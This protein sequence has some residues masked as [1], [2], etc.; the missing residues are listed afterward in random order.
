MIQVIMSG[1]L[2]RMGRAIAENVKLEENMRI[3]AGVDKAEGTADFPIYHD[4]RDVKEAADVIVDFSNPE[5]LQ[6]ICQYAE[7]HNIALVVGTTGIL[8]EDR[9]KLHAAAQKVPVI[10]SHNVHVGTYVFINLVKQA[11]KLLPDFDVEIVERHHNQKIDA[12]SGTALMIADAIR[13]V[14]NDAEYV[15]QRADKIQKRAKNE[16]GIYS[17]R[18]GNIIGQHTVIFAGDDEVIELNSNITSRKV[19][20]AGAVQCAKFIVEKAPG[21]YTL[22]DVVNYLENK[23]G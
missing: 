13:E 19:L 10:A 1:A 20:S 4:I 3:V 22:F 18:A 17:V 2:G 6:N 11:A 12:P 14:R 16:I 7:E 9:K 5:N 21:Y 23:E 8:E 15:Y